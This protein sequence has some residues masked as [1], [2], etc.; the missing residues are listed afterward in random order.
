MSS[1]SRAS[2]SV[3]A[4]EYCREIEAY[5]CRKN[6][7]HL[8]RIVGP[9]FERVCDWAT[10]GVPFK[11]VCQGIDRCF[12][13]YYA[14]GPRR[15]PVQIDFCEA[16]I[17]DAFDAW[18]RAIGVWLPGADAGGDGAARRQHRSLPEHLK[19]V[20]ESLSARLAASTAM[21]ATLRHTLESIADDVSALSDLP[22]PIRGEARSRVAER[23]A[24]LDRRMID[25]V[26]DGS[27]A[28]LVLA[29]RN[30]AAGQLA[31][32]R[33]RMSSDAYTE[34]IEAALR[35]LLRERERLPTLTFE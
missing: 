29:L 18:R 35:G 28:E 32:F 27:D 10:R 20:L 1:S 11:V 33:E 13:R 22:S 9:S 24:E 4:D 5:L 12:E 21:S 23:L 16:D 2:V 15:R 30:D 3:T 26:R 34:A 25:A 31:P 17:L 19:R 7:G 14:K 6:D 8:I